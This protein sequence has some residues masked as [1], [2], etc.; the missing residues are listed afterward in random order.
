MNLI[1]FSKP[2]KIFYFHLRQCLKRFLQRG[3]RTRLLE[4]IPCQVIQL[5]RPAGPHC[6]R[7][8]D[9]ATIASAAPAAATP[10][11][12]PAP[13]WPAP[14]TFAKAPRQ[15]TVYNWLKNV[16]QYTGQNP[17]AQFAY[18][19]QAIFMNLLRFIS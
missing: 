7:Q 2:Q 3:T 14:T 16:F 11:E 5:P 6:C 10:A 1:L 4:Q 13:A 17:I 15:G 12:N 8:T 9:L 19:T 18:F